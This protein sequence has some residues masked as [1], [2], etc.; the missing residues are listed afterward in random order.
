T[1]SSASLNRMPPPALG[2]VAPAPVVAAEVPLVPEFAPAVVDPPLAAELDAVFDPA[3]AGSGSGVNARESA[4]LRLII[5]K[6]PTTTINSAAPPT[7]A[8]SIA[9]RGGRPGLVVVAVLPG[10]ANCGAATT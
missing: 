1:A 7:I 9:F 3:V 10:G 2:L 4:A 6:T 5:T 8:A